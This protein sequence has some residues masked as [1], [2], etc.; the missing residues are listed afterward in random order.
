MKAEDWNELD[1]LNGKLSV[2]RARRADAMLAF[3]RRDTIRQ[4]VSEAL[5]LAEREAKEAEAVM[6]D[7]SAAVESAHAAVRQ[8]RD[9]FADEFGDLPGEIDGRREI[10]G[11]ES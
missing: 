5:R 1:E 3:G 2:L 11:S 7:L 9:R 6:L 4:A 8:F 10:E